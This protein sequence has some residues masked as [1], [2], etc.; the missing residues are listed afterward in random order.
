[1]EGKTMDRNDM[2]N[3]LNSLVET[4]INYYILRDLIDFFKTCLKRGPITVKYPEKPSDFL[5]R[6]SKKAGLK[7]SHFILGIILCIIVSFIATLVIF[8]VLEMF[9]FG[10]FEITDAKGFKYLFVLSSIGIILLSR[11]YIDDRKKIKKEENKYESD[12]K[13]YVQE[14]KIAS[15]NIKLNNAKI[16]IMKQEV[17]KLEKQIQ[18][19]ESL[20]Q[21]LYRKNI[22]NCDYRS[23]ECIITFYEYFKYGKCETMDEAYKKYLEDG[24]LGKVSL[25]KGESILEMLSFARETQ[26]YFILKLKNAYE[27]E[28][29]LKFSIDELAEKFIKN[30]YIAKICASSQISNYNLENYTREICMSSQISNFCVE[31]THFNNL[32]IDEM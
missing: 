29:K 6:E 5:I 3:Y 11:I 30:D 13:M 4:T 19:T 20:L 21:D 23:L 24:K 31:Q 12:C 8:I 25:Y 26:E 9:S 1:M 27:I 28:K 32:V 2:E 7:T 16:L 18:Q 10:R 14:S 17:S 22:I 15:K